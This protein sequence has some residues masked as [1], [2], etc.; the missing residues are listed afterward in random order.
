MWFIRVCAYTELFIYTQCGPMVL[1]LN[2]FT[3][4]LPMPFTGPRVNYVVE[5][6]SHKNSNWR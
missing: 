1:E 6:V 3:A 2:F 5:T 4:F